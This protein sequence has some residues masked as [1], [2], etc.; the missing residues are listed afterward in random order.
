LQR[1]V[2]AGKQALGRRLFIPGGAVDLA[3]KEQAA[4]LPR[5]EA[6]FERARIEIV[7]LDGVPGRRMWAFSSPFMLRTRS[8][9]MSNGRL[10]EMPLG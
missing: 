2:D 4:D 8:Y 9:W 1:G 7:V 5:L 3:G 10:V 6:A